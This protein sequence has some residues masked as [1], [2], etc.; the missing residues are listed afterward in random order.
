MSTKKHLNI[1]VL[2]AGGIAISFLTE[3]A[4]SRVVNLDALSAYMWIVDIIRITS[5]LLATSL[6]GIKIQ[7][8]SFVVLAVT[9]GMN[10]A[11]Y[12]PSINSQ[13][14]LPN[15]YFCMGVFFIW[16]FWLIWEGRKHSIDSF[17]WKITIATISQIFLA[18]L[19]LVLIFK[20]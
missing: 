1:G 19:I 5:L 16:L 18:N 3:I 4:I 2:V 13:N 17:E 10:Y 14:K 8:P 20:R 15:A 9:A 6:L 12:I 11:Y 7:L